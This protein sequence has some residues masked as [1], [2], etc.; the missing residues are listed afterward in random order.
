MIK[1]TLLKHLS[2][3][4]LFTM[5][6]LPFSASADVLPSP[7]VINAKAWLLMSYE[8][9]QVIASFNENEPLAPASL[10]KIM[11]SYVVG[12]EINAGHIN[13][14]DLVIISE[15]AWG[16]KFPGSSK[17]FLNIGDNVTVDQLNKGVIIS[18]G[19]D[20]TV[21]LAEHVAG[22]Q[23]AFIE[24]MNRQ[25]EVIGMQNTYFTNPHGLDA[26]EQFTTAY[27]MA[28]L[29]RAL[30]KDLPEMYGLFK[31][32]S[33][34][35][36]DIKQGNRNGLLW[37]TTLNVDGVKTGHTSKAGYSLVSSAEQSG[38]R[39]IAVVMGTKST[40]TRRSESKKLLTWGFRFYQDLTP[41]FDGKELEPIKVW[42]G[43]PSKVSVELGDGGVITVPR[44]QR[45]NLEHKVFYNSNL[46]API[47]K[48]EQVGKIEWYLDEEILIV[49]PILALEDVVEAPW[50]GAAVDTI[51]RPIS[52]W[53]S[54]QD[55]EPEK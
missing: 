52:Q 40:G 25:A 7:P 37:D 15:N 42:Y 36:Q 48:G 30:I 6:S 3:F 18:S 47:S 39:F 29:T 5:A 12:K 50:Y 22:H 35:F 51:W 2:L 11:T 41:T 10:T 32:K 13:N 28:I 44:R 1:T 54:T 38:Q 53:F 31:E 27:D 23:A 45:K 34:T 24:M 21:A 20:A 46:E 14:D 49:Q 8:S 55:W 33:F 19:N 43:S 9:G 17:M 26:D 4:T 16:K